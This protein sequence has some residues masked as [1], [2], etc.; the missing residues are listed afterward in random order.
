MRRSQRLQP[1]L[2]LAENKVQD[3]ARILGQEQQRLAHLQQQLAELER[4]RDLY[5]QEMQARSQTGLDIRQLRDFHAFVE[6]LEAAL[7]QQRQGLNRQQQRCEQ[8][9]LDYL[10]ER[11][12]A[13]ALD[14]V[15]VRTRQEEA[16]QGARREQNELDELAQRLRPMIDPEP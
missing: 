13:Q 10:A 14:Q 15:I 16:A 2:D 4:Y 5:Q 6:R 11:A 9:R 1:V 12:H 7:Q 3:L 8:V